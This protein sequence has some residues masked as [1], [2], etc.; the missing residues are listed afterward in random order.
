MKKKL[1]LLSLLTVG[2]LSVTACG[3]AETETKS[4]KDVIRIGGTSISQ[5]YY[6]AC[7]EDFEK[8]G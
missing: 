6:D 8:K 1:V 2:M 5:I 3:K 4:E 7:K